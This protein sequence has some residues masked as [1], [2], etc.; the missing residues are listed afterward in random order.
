MSCSTSSLS[1]RNVLAILILILV[2]RTQDV[3]AEYEPFP[4]YKLILTADEI[5]H[6]EIVSLDEKFFYLKIEGSLTNLDGIVSVARFSDWTCAQ[7]WG[8]YEVGQ[9]VFLFLKDNKGVYQTL[10]AGNEGELPILGDSVLVNGLSLT[11]D[12]P[13]FM[14]QAHYDKYGFSESFTRREYL[15]YGHQF[16]GHG[17]H[18]DEFIKSVQAVIDCFHLQIGEFYEIKSVRE[19]CTSEFKEYATETLKIFRW[20]FGKLMRYIRE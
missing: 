5:V 10:S 19:I 12:P 11:P 8:E 6:G 18:L 4:L 9:R 2:S 14:G 20:T 16:I 7:R 13:S 17:F 3:R 15:V 1:I